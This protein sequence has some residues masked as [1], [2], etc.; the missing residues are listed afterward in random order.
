MFAY[1]YAG[2]CTKEN[3][4]KYI[5]SF[6]TLKYQRAGFAFS[7]GISSCLYQIFCVML[8]IPSIVQK[9][10]R[11]RQIEWVEKVE[12]FYDSSR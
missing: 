1:Q 4:T 2:V 12:I 3:C 7:A 9:E 5:I 8:D 6:S 10:E 11:T